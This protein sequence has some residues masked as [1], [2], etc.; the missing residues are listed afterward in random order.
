M[1]IPACFEITVAIHVWFAQVTTHYLPPYED[2][3]SD[4][5]DDDVQQALFDGMPSS[6]QP[7]AA[8]DPIVVD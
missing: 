6:P 1:H 8:A 2:Y 3:E 5:E 7:G 4:S